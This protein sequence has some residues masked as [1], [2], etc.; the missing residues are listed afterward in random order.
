MSDIID[1]E[2][3]FPGYELTG[4]GHALLAALMEEAGLT[5]EEV[6]K[7]GPEKS[8]AALYRAQK[9]LLRRKSP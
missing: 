8:A 7:M 4:K 9:K 2:Q 5:I 3:C 1:I 6:K